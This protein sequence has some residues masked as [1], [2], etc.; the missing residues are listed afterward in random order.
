MLPCCVFSSQTLQFWLTFC[1][2]SGIFTLLPSKRYNH[3]SYAGLSV[4]AV[5][6]SLPLS[7]DV[8]LVL[9]DCCTPSSLLFHASHVFLLISVSSQTMWPLCVYARERTRTHV[10]ACARTHTHT[11]THRHRFFFHC[12]CFSECFTV[13]HH[14]DLDHIGTC[15]AASL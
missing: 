3:R 15:Q 9:C 13:C 12:V 11:H 4:T 5:L 8:L 7:P 14:T 2:V 1:C 10:R 6:P